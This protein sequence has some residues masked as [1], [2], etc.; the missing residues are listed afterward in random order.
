LKPRIF[1][2]SADYC[3]SSAKIR[4]ICVYQRFLLFQ[5]CL[6]RFRRS[7]SSHPRSG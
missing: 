7:L 3:G 5:A 4:G 6:F 1:E 2:D